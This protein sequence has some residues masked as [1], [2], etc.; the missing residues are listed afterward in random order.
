[1]AEPPKQKCNAYQEDLL[2]KRDPDDICPLCKKLGLEVE[3]GFHKSR[4][5]PPGEYC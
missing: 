1:M 4:D 3:V 5:A 2:K